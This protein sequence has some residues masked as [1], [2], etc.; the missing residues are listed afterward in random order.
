MPV[1]LSAPAAAWADVAPRVGGGSELAL[2]RSY[3]LVLPRGPT[4]ERRLWRLRAT[5]GFDFTTA[6]SLGLLL[7]YRTN[8]AYGRWDNARKVWGDVIKV[9]LR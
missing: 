6:G 3:P 4:G 1:A 5:L 2:L 8:A 9:V 7:A